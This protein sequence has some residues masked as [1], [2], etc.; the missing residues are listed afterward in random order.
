MVR[1][2]K[3][4]MRD[5]EGVAHTVE[6]TAGSLYEAVALGMAAIRTDE[7]ASGIAQGLNPVTV[8]V[9]SVSVKHEV[10]L[11]DFTKW[12][13]KANGSPREMTERKR[14]RSILGMGASKPDT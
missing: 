10:R 4:T 9:S 7:W 1:C 8:Q 6:V 11:M 13:D 14:I 2:C 3:V 12:L 5:L